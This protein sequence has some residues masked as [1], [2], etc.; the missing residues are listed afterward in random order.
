MSDDNVVTFPG[1]S[2]TETPVFT[3]KHFESEEKLIEDLSE[4][5]EK[6]N[7]KVSNLA[8]IGALNLYANLVSLGSLEGGEA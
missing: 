1:V 3:D 7:G 5:L 2:D 6:Y 4:L 8:L